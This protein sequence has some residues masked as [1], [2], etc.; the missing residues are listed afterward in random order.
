MILTTPGGLFTLRVPGRGRSSVG[1]APEWHS[2]GQGFEP[3]RLH[4]L[5]FPLFVLLFLFVFLSRL[6]GQCLA[7]C[8]KI[9]ESGPMLKLSRRSFALIFS[10]LILTLSV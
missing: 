10:T 2:G 4:H 6:S 8:R 5:Q 3:P 7:L 9:P 1:R